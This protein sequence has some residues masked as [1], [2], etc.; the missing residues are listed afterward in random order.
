VAID[1]I[2]T[3]TAFQ[4]SDLYDSVPAGFYTIDYM[5]VGLPVMEA[6][7]N[8]PLSGPAAW[9]PV[10]PAA[11]PGNWGG[12]NDPAVYH[13]RAVW[14]YV[15]NTIS[16]TCCMYWGKR[17]GNKKIGLHHLDGGSDDSF[18][19]YVDDLLVGHYADQGPSEIWHQT[20]FDVGDL[21]GVH[22]ITIVAT[23]PAGPYWNPFGQ[24]VIDE[25][26]TATDNPQPV[27]KC[28]D[29]NADGWVDLNDF[30]TFAVCFTGSTVSIHS[31][32]CCQDDFVC[33]DLDGDNDVDLN[34]FATFA[35]WFNREPACEP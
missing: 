11:H 22:L 28:G 20:W 33:S 8:V 3:A 32:E 4:G 24:V 12:H 7:H 1:E 23:A 29:I 30:A 27:C 18:D 35:V 14:G 17:P 31:Y 5:D 6:W 26:A 34:D 2:A 15:E 13:Y 25:I 21:C 19:L 9:G 10:E 16:A